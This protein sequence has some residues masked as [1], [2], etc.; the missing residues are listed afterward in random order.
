VH[1]NPTF[2]EPVNHLGA[3]LADAALQAGLNYNACKGKS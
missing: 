3:V 1:R 2:R